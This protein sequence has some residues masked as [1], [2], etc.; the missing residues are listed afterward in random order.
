MI[1]SPT[2]LAVPV[3]LGTLYFAGV[4]LGFYPLDGSSS[5][6][7]H[8]L[9]RH[10]PDDEKEKRQASLDAPNPADDRL[11]RPSPVGVDPKRASGPHRSNGHEKT[12][13]PAAQEL[14]LLGAPQQADA[15]SNHAELGIDE[16]IQSVRNSAVAP[17]LTSTASGKDSQKVTAQIAAEQ[18]HAER[19]DSGRQST[20]SGPVRQTTAAEEIT[21]RLN[22]S[23]LVFPAEPPSADSS[24]GQRE[25][26]STEVVAACGRAIAS[27]DRMEN[28]DDF[29][30]PADLSTLVAYRAVSRLGAL[31]IDPNGPMVLQVLSEVTEPVVLA[32]FEPLCL[33]WIRWAERKT[34]GI[35]LI[36][37]LQDRAGETVFE[38]VD[39]TRLAIDLPPDWH[40]PRHSRCAA[41]G[42]MINPAESR[43]IELIA[44][45]EV[46]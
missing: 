19:Q 33:E 37:R 18:Q 6:S 42:K 21:A 17:A 40:L 16:V 38:L 27:I 23:L 29:S 12:T 34:D 43:R 44:G 31:P 13:E 26:E 39:G 4:N 1:A 35:L 2:L 5:I 30:Q 41:I 25:T 8:S 24:A 14:K 7:S 45:V 20:E 15:W 28:R 46:R 36:G 10:T 9:L 32:Q 3:I 11:S 22:R